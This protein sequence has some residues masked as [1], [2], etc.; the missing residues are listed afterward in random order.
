MKGG[1]LNLIPIL[2]P[3]VLMVALAAI[4]IVQQ[5]SDRKRFALFNAAQAGDL[6]KV[7]RLVQQG[8]PINLK[9]AGSFGWTPLIA[10]IYENETNVAHYLIGTGADVNIPDVDGKT[11]LMW[12]V[13]GGD[14]ALPLVRELIAHGADLDA[15][16]KDGTTVLSYARSDPPKSDVVKAIEAALAD[17]QRHSGQ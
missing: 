14:E 3:L 9:V 11:P 13:V 16:D 4:T 8:S 17:R 12:A 15:K 1:R 7:K 10:A 5:K 6:E 2:L